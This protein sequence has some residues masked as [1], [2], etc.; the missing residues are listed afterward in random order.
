MGGGGPGKG[1]P[2]PPK[3]LIGG[4][5]GGGGPGWLGS[6][7]VGER[8]VTPPRFQGGTLGADLMIKNSS[9]LNMFFFFR[10]LRLNQLGK[11]S[12]KFCVTF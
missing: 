12:T 9:Y 6:V 10:N 8:V 4:R 5:G 1:K 7:Q 2:R 3:Q 11:T